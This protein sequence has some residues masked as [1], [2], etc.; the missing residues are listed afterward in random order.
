[1]S[2]KVKPKDTKNPCGDCRWDELY[3]KGDIEHCMGCRWFS[4]WE[5]DE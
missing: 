3:R 5:A 1:M 2:E 4:N